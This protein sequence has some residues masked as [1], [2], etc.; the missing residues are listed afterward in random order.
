MK[1][2]KPAWL[3]D[4]KPWWFWPAAGWL[5]CVLGVRLLGVTGLVG[6]WE[7]TQGLGSLVIP[8]WVTL[9]LLGAAWWEH[10]KWKDVEDD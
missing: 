9:M 10:R 5:P 8:T 7:G 6:Q 2:E 1:R 3:K 4:G